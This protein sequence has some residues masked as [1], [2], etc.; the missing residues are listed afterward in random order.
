MRYRD[1]FGLLKFRIPLGYLPLHSESAIGRT[2]LASWLWPERRISITFQHRQVPNSAT[3]LEWAETIIP[4]LDVPGKKSIANFVIMRDGGT[5]VSTRQVAAGNVE[6]VAI[7]RGGDLDAVIH[8]FAQ[9]QDIRTLTNEL[10]EI[11]S[12]LQMPHPSRDSEDPLL[13]LV[14]SARTQLGS[15]RQL[16]QQGFS[17]GKPRLTTALGVILAYEELAEGPSRVNYLWQAR[18]AADMY[19]DSSAP[20]PLE[21]GRRSSH[22]H[23]AR[24]RRRCPVPRV[25]AVRGSRRPRSG[26]ATGPRTAYRRFHA[27]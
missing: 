17:A 15:I 25:A 14:D 27:F 9:D 10:R 20:V 23:G 5:C 6:Q 24:S 26:P 22:R 3:G 2:K 16:F 18:D 21:P 8:V 12:T 1:P 13:P 19:L 7:V 11:L 4:A